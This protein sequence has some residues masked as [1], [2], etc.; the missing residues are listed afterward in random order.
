MPVQHV[1]DEIRFVAQ[2]AAQLF[3]RIVKGQMFRQVTAPEEFLSA[4][5]TQKRLAVGRHTASRF[6]IGWLRTSR[7]DCYFLLV[8]NIINDWFVVRRLLINGRITWSHVTG[9][10]NLIG[11]LDDSFHG[12]RFH[13]SDRME[14]QSAVAMVALVRT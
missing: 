14:I 4:H 1:L 10:F 13:V 6:L 7:S 8:S 9:C 5:V 12:A 11:C 2:V 3:G